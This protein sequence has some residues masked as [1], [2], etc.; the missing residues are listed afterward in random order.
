MIILGEA[1]MSILCINDIQNGFGLDIGD[2]SLKLLRLKF[3]KT[4]LHKK[5]FTIKNFAEIKLPEGIMNNGEMINESLLESSIKTLLEEAGSLPSKA[6]VVSLPESKTFLKIIDVVATNKKEIPA[7]I[8]ELLPRVLPV[9]ADE[10]YFDWQI[11]ADDDDEKSKKGTKIRLSQKDKTPKKYTIFLAAAPKTIVETFLRILNKLKLV[12]IAFELEAVALSRALLGPTPDH[13]C[14]PR[15]I[16]DFGA[17]QTSLIFTKM[18]VPSASITLPISGNQ[19]TSMIADNFKISFEE[20]EKLK[21]ICGLDPKKCDN[22]LLPVV[23]LYIND[24]CKKISRALKTV[25]DLSPQKTMMP[26]ILSGGGANMAK[27]DAVIS[28]ILKIKNRKGT[29]LE[30]WRIESKNKKFNAI[31]LGASTVIGLALRAA[32]YPFP[33]NH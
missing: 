8:S 12:P 13:S 27:L 7:K 24:T 18:G 33:T 2:R 25:P 23:D 15:V 28:K 21:K 14:P 3:K 6:V 19:L 17:T 30:N 20:A 10:I 31:Q 5:K 9:S 4:F 22:K 11:V 16:I 32:L 1:N 29:P 26:I